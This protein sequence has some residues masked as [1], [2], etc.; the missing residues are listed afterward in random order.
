MYEELI[1][2]PLFKRLCDA[3]GK[4]F[5]KDRGYEQKIGVFKYAN[6]Q[7]YYFK[8]AVI[9]G[10]ERN[11][12]FFVHIVALENKDTGY[13]RYYF[14]LCIYFLDNVT[15]GDWK[16]KDAVRM[17]LNEY[18]CNSKC[19]GTRCITYQYFDRIYISQVFYFYHGCMPHEE[20]IFEIIDQFYFNEDNTDIANLIEEKSWS[21]R[22]YPLERY[23]IWQ[24]EQK[25]R[26]ENLKDTE[27]PL[28]PIDVNIV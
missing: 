7:D 5:N 21:N 26:K 12:E 19:D 1:N 9:G 17:Q 25:S 22:N 24:R 16:L 13:Y 3:T 23:L 10:S 20:E 15:D 6:G 8:K 14:G 4:W 11:A 2:T 18:N 28:P 27:N